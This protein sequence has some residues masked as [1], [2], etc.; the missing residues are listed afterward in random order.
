MG[1]YQDRY[2]YSMPQE[3][4][5]RRVRALTDYWDTRYGT[6]TEWTGNRGRIRGRA[7]R[8]AFDATFTINPEVMLGEMKVSFLAVKMG[9]RKYLKSKL[10]EYLDPQK[11]VEEL[12]NRL[13]GL[14][15]IRV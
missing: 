7:F 13:I 12:Q 14:T 1:F 4:A 5:V 8:I 11:T 9:G 3:E 15:A 2:P 10:D 6:R